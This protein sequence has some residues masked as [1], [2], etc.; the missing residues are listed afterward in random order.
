MAWNLLAIVLA[1]LPQSI[2]AGE[3]TP[4]PVEGIEGTLL[5]SSDEPGEELLRS[6][7]ALAGNRQARLVCVAAAEDASKEPART[8]ATRTREALFR[9]WL[10]AGGQSWLTI[11]FPTLD[12]ASRAPQGEQ[13]TALRQ[14][15]GVWFAGGDARQLA[16][17]LASAPIAEAFAD[18]R[19]RHVPLG[20]TLAWGQAISEPAAPAAATGSSSPDGAGPSP[21]S[22]WLPGLVVAGEEAAARDELSRQL[23]AHPASVGWSFE[24]GSALL[25]RGR[26]IQWQG[27]GEVQV[28][29]AASAGRPAPG[30][31]LNERQRLADLNAL[32]RAAVARQTASYPP[33][34]VPE[35]RVEKGTLVIVGGGGTPPGLLQKFVEWA[36]GA[37]A[38]LVVIPISTPEPLPDRDPSAEAF[39]RAGAKE[40][41][42]LTGRTPAEVDRPEVWELFERASGIWFGGGRQW[43]F[44][45]AYEGTTALH[46]M[47][48]V[49][50]RGGV[51]GGSSAGATI[52]GDYLVRGHPLG[53]HIMM[54]DGYERSFAFLP[55]TAIDQHFTQRKRSTDLVQLLQRYPQFLGIGIDEATALVVRGSVGEVVGKHHVHLFDTRR[56]NDAGIP[57]QIALPAGAKYDLVERK[58]LE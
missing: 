53:P 54:A 44:V 49:L 18:L 35:P 7:V 50:Q 41:H 1:V 28:Q 57:H 46:K 5:L 37:E 38:R 45:D 27:T 19:R 34:Q 14:A 40:V 8:L 30:L 52:Q 11:T 22:C 29:Y 6:F 48:Q 33:A 23:Q 13:A 39:R 43:R 9:R 17:W 2:G 51:I 3:V 32:R 58:V 21:S 24:R 31:K 56:S 15:T 42:V 4:I 16:D 55:G 47:H 25:I 26:A 20:G 10:A 12:S 36:G